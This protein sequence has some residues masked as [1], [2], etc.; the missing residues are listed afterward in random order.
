MQDA[1]NPP[2]VALAEYRLLAKACYCLTAAVAV[3]AAAAAAVGGGVGAGCARCASTNLEGCHDAI[4]VNVGGCMRV[5]PDAP[6]DPIF[7][8]HH[9][10]GDYL[11]WRYQQARGRFVSAGEWQTPAA[12]ASCGL[13]GPFPQHS[14]LHEQCTAWASVQRTGG[15][16]IA[17]VEA[18]RSEWP[19]AAVRVRQAE[20]RSMPGQTVC[21]MHSLR[22][23][24]SSMASILMGSAVAPP[25]PHLTPPARLRAAPMANQIHQRHRF[26]LWAARLQLLHRHHLPLPQRVGFLRC[27]G[28]CR[29]SG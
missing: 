17:R 15:H 18:N 23:G 10:T 29:R 16:C 21:H 2:L 28:T 7:Q 14:G 8:L 24:S 26:A 9:T 20:T 6:R 3:P 5:V 11:V 27:C 25:P 19:G 1:C 22:Y 12:A 4:H 13:L